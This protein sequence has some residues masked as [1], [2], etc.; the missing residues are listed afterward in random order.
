MVLLTMIITI[1][2][3]VL[4]YIIKGLFKN[5]FLSESNI[6]FKIIG[7]LVFLL[8]IWILWIFLFCWALI[9]FAL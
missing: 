7:F 3:I 8:F 6:I 1:I 2:C 5:I 4:I 9:I